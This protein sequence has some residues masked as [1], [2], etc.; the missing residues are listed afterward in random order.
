MQLFPGQA[1]CFNDNSRVGC[2]DINSPV[3]FLGYAFVTIKDCVCATQELEDRR[4]AWKAPTNKA[5][6]GALWRYTST[7]GPAVGGAVT[8]PGASGETS[9]YSEV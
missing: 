4:A 3:T 8:H 6:S 2:G 9:K 1:P 7:V 5:G